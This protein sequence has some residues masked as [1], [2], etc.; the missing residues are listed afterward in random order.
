VWI[1][2]FYE[3]LFVGD[4]ELYGLDY[5]VLQKV[6]DVPPRQRPKVQ[7]VYYALQSLHDLNALLAQRAIMDSLAVPQRFNCHA[8][9]PQE[10]VLAVKNQ[11]CVA[12]SDETWA[13]IKIRLDYG[14]RIWAVLNTK[15]Y[16]AKQPAKHLAVETIE[17]KTARSEIQQ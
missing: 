12:P 1:C 2:F 15:W 3:T 10:A 11:N 7:N 9:V 5:W 14:Y 8:A 4:P 13:S 16:R 6:Q 17:F